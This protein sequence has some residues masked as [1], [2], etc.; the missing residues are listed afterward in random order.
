M[1]ARWP[2]KPCVS[3]PK[4]CLNGAYCPCQEGTTIINFE[5]SHSKCKCS[6]LLQT[7][8]TGVQFCILH[9]NYTSVFALIRLSVTLRH[10]HSCGTKRTTPMGQIYVHR[11]LLGQLS[12][13]QDYSVWKAVYIFHINETKFKL[14]K[15]VM[16]EFDKILLILSMKKMFSILVKRTFLYFCL[17]NIQCMVQ[18]WL[19]M[20][21]YVTYSFF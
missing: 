6:L 15:I 14:T 1:Q 7:S 18:T 3:T 21:S 10:D 13:V 8:E 5:I 19:N 2:V 12:S 20:A 16:K 9:F 11:F 17:F 4:R